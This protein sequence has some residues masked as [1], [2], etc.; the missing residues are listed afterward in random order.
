MV[1]VQPLIPATL[2]ALPRRSDA[3]PNY[4]GTLALYTVTQPSGHETRVV[5]LKT[6]K[7]RR[8]DGANARWIPDTNDVLFVRGGKIY[9]NCPTGEYIV[10]EVDVA[11][12]QVRRVN[13]GVAFVAKKRASQTGFCVFDA[14]AVTNGHVAEPPTVS[15]WCS[16]LE[17]KEGKWTLSDHIALP[18]MDAFSLS[19]HAVAFT[20]CDQAYLLP[21][22]SYTQ[23]PSCPVRPIT[24]AHTGAI[25]NLRISPDGTTI[26]FIQDGKLYTCWT[27]SL[28][29]TVFPDVTPRAFE[30][31]GWC[32]RLILSSVS[33]G[34][35][36]LSTLDLHE[37]DPSVVFFDKGSV[38]SFWP[39]ARGNWDTLLVSSSSMTESQV[40]SIVDVPTHQAK[41]V[42]STR[43]GVKFAVMSCVS[44]FWYEGTQE[45]LHAWMAQPA[46]FSA[47]KL[48][49][50]IVLHDGHAL[51]KWDA[52]VSRLYEKNKNKNR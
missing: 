34:R 24:L 31:A 52:Q 15:A 30:F 14:N 47:E 8:I 18:P 23:A 50:W 51:D 49:P 16:T 17:K 28:L 41:T 26:A 4:N 20:R 9:V 6:R 12:F 45:C 10:A 29:A 22:E 5:D 42:A 38:S 36:V 7:T 13:G 1:H 11:Y 2:A 44:D 3:V 19:A 25:S 33:C 27:D 48:Y 35:V 32:D 43:E 37:R 40:W 39:L 21:L 46:D